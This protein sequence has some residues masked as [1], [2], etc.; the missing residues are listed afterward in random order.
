M[1]RLTENITLAHSSHSYTFVFVCLSQPDHAC[2][3]RDFPEPA[4]HMA[5]R[6]FGAVM[7]NLQ[8]NPASDELVA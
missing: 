4:T 1:E 7:Q 6:L 2:L 8:P 5:R 3:P